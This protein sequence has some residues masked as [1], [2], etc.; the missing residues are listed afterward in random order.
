MNGRETGRLAAADLQSLMVNAEAVPRLAGGLSDAL[1][2]V[3]LDLIQ[4][5]TPF[6]IGMLFGQKEDQSG[7]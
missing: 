6:H 5:L 4:S 7:I 2:M 3:S 1:R